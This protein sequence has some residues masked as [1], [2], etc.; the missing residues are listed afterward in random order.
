MTRLGAFAFA[1]TVL[2]STASFAQSV[3]ATCKDGT[4]YSGEQRS[5]ACAR[6]GG[7]QAWGSAAAG[8]ATPAPAPSATQTPAAPKAA[9]PA[10]TSSPT[11]ANAPSRSAAGAPSAGQVWVNTKTNVYHCPGTRWYGAT[12]AGSYMTEGAAK[13]AGARA[14]H[15]KACS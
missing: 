4:S 12:K 9:A 7:V 11:T 5:G 8:A 10:P 13:A 15:G 1:F 3:T 14:D 2:F 6:H